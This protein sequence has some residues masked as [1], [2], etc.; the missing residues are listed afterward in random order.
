MILSNTSLVLLTLLILVSVM[1]Q[2]LSHIISCQDCSLSESVTYNENVVNITDSFDS[3]FWF[4]QISDIHISIFQD[5]SRISEFYQFCNETV[6][7]IKPSVVIASGDLT[8]A[9]AKNELGSQQYEEEWQHYWNTLH[10]THVTEKTIWL[11]TRGNH[12]NFNLPSLSSPVNFYRKYSVQG[13]TYARSYVYHLTLPNQQDI[14]FVALDA[15]L[16][17]GPRRPFNFIGVLDTPEIER[18]ESIIRSNANSTYSIW[19]GHYPTSTILSQGSRHVRDIMAQDKKAV[20]YLCGHLH[21]LGGAVPHMYTRQQNGILELE[22]ADWKHS[23]IFRVAAFDHGLFSFTDVPHGQWPIILVTNPKHAQ[24]LSPKEPVKSM[25]HSKHIRILVFSR[26]ELREVAVRLNSDS[27][28]KPCRHVSG[29]LYVVPWEPSLYASG[30]HTLH[31]K[32]VDSTGSTTIISHPFSLDGTRIPFNFLP[33]LLLMANVT[34]FFQLCFGLLILASVVVL[35]YLRS[36]SYHVSMGSRSCH[37][38]TRINFINIWLRKL[39]LAANMDSFYYFLALFPVYLAIGPWTVGY[40]ID[41]DIAIIFAWGTV[42]LDGRYLPGALT[43]TYGFF[44]LMLFHGPMI[45]VLSHE[46]DRRL[47]PKIKRSKKATGLRWVYISLFV[48]PLFILQASTVHSFS[49]SYGFISG[50]GPFVLW[51]L[52]ICLWLFVQSKTMPE[53]RIRRAGAMWLNHKFKRR[54]SASYFEDQKLDLRGA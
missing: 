2:N 46:L 23:R 47:H 45:L 17:P 20:A 18:V 1:I 24:F 52:L 25:L 11:D 29:P 26:S 40:V 49:L 28:W 6:D 38:I 7:T 43:Y 31:V 3:L 34:T 37:P 12:D 36:S 8:D 27:Q 16:D 19:F 41:D 14:A 32:A 22:L 33:R 35:S 51:P 9:K 39:T 42:F 15:C 21:Q 48:C 53:T 30:I 44:Y 4:V 5:E 50:L 13:K 10:N 54:A